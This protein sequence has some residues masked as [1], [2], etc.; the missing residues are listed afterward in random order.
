VGSWSARAA[1]AI[2]ASTAESWLLVPEHLAHVLLYTVGSDLSAG[3]LGLPRPDP[4]PASAERQD[5]PQMLAAADLERLRLAFVLVTAVADA[6]AP[7]AAAD[8]LR[9][10]EPGLGWLPPIGLLAAAPPGDVALALI[11]SVHAFVA[12]QSGVRRN[13]G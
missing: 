13:D 4:D 1:G 2:A 12:L 8:W 9:L 3:C 10:G 5:L 6:V 11:Y 7:A